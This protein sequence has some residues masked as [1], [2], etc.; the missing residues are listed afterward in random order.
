MAFTGY[1]RTAEVHALVQAALDGDL[2]AVPRPQLL[3]GLPTGFVAAMGMFASPLD[4]V[5]ADIG[6]LNQTE[7]LADRSVP[8]EVYLANAAAQ[9]RLRSSTQA[10]TFA[11]AAS[12]VR[13]MAEGVP[14]LPEVG[15]LPEIVENEQIVADNDSVAIAFL[16]RGVELAKAVA[17]IAVPRFLNGVAQQLPTGGPNVHMGTAWLVAP[18][19]VITN[20]HVINARRS[21]EGQAAPADLVLQVQGSSVEFGLDTDEST[22]VVATVGKV[23]ASSPELDYALLA[24]TGAPEGPVPRINPHAVVLTPASRLAVNIVQHPGG[25]AKQV[26]LRNNLVSGTTADTIRYFTDTD[27]GSSGSPVCDDLW[28]V[29]ALHR[30]SRHTTNTSYQ[31]RTEAYVN[32]G[33]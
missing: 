16:A 24:V 23:V 21:D 25:R 28:R 22:P 32:F 5:Q 13:G 1:L 3:A 12:R 27:Y 20:H 2:L 10:S 8:L 29:V 26:A 4:Q 15:D 33:S 17:R 11:D 9:L 14:P 18:G 19:F 31:G 7:R 30:G 6:K